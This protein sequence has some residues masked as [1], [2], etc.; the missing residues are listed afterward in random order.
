[1]AMTQYGYKVAVRKFGDEA[2]DAVTKELT[3]VHNY[4]ALSPQDAALLT[5]EQR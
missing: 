4:E 1:M 5:Y 2:K 3:Q